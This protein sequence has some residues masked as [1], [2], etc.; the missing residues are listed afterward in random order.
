MKWEGDNNQFKEKTCTRLS[1]TGASGSLN[2]TLVEHLRFGMILYA[3]CGVWNAGLRMESAKRRY[4]DRKSILECGRLQPSLTWPLVRQDRV[5]S[6]MFI[7]NPTQPTTPQPNPTHPNPT[8]PRCIRDGLV[9]ALW[10]NSGGLGWSSKGGLGV[11]WEVDWGWIGGGL[12]WIG[13]DW[14]WC[15]CRCAIE[16]LVFGVLKRPENHVELKRI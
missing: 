8:Q 1:Q 7:P 14:H 4:R 15:R 10:V 13:V 6:E 5:Q 2:W 11:D 9:G 16:F 12:A 3:L